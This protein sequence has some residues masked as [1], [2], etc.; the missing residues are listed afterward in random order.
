[1]IDVAI[2]IVERERIERETMRE[3]ERKR[4]R[5]R[6]GGRVRRKGGKVHD[7]HSFIAKYPRRSRHTERWE[8]TTTYRD[9]KKQPDFL[10]ISETRPTRRRKRTRGGKD[11]GELR[12]RGREREGERE[13]EGDETVSDRLGE[14]PANPSTLVPPF[15]SAGSL[16]LSGIFF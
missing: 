9:R 12:G 14:A 8:V 5:G 2:W 11:G 13:N 6:E 16:S 4:T 3:G 15:H 7:S 1:M 10:R